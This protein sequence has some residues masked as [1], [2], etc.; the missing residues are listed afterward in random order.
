MNHIIQRILFF[1][2]LV[3]N[4]LFVDKYASRITE[5]HLFVSLVYLILGALIVW[6]VIKKL[7]PSQHTSKWL[8]AIGISFFTLAIIVQYFV[9]PISLQVDRWSAIHNFLAG[10]LSG[11]YPY[12][13]QTHLGGYGSPFP[14]WQILHLPFYFLG[15]VGLSIF[16]VVLAFIGTLS[17]IYSN[18]VA[19]MATILLVISPAFWYEVA[20]RSD[21]ITNIMLA[22]II[23]EWLSYKRIKL[24]DYPIPIGILS[25]LVLS[26]RLIALIPIC[27]LYGYE[28]LRVDW[29]KQS[30][31]ILTTITTF[32]ITFLPFLF[33]EGSTLLFFEYNPFILQTR[34]GSLGVLLVFAVIA[35]AMTIYLKENQTYRAALTGLILNIL[36]AMAFVEKMWQQHLWDALYS[37]AFDITYLTIGIPFYIVHLSCFWGRKW[38]LS[39]NQS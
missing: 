37:S 3:I 20:V 9:D 29:R 1:L 13:Q 34:Q 22:A 31:F 7:I 10:M 5:F 18:K 28:F 30:V 25:G 35:I 39:L 21:L 16:I 38:G 8:M 2:F 11:E 12:G 19:L 23:V 14:V 17:Y 32:V 24:A 4:V 33:W 6:I 15:N 26:T 36:V 27:V